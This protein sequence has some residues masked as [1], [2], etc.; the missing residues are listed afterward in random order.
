MS[1]TSISRF[2]HLWHHMPMAVEACVDVV[3]TVIKPEV[4][5]DDDGVSRTT[6]RP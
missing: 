5:W 3:Y 2:L 4:N 6:Q 1:H